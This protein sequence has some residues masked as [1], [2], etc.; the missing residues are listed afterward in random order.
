LFVPVEVLRVR[1]IKIGN[2]ACW[3][4][5]VVEVLGEEQFSTAFRDPGT[6]QLPP[7]PNED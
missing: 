6:A 4:A 7:S 5:G 3:R 1:Q 2:F